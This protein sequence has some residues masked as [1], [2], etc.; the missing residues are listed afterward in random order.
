MV[1]T[2]NICKQKISSAVQSATICKSMK[3]AIAYLC[4]FFRISRSP[5]ERKH[6]YKGY[7]YNLL[8]PTRQN[9]KFR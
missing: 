4:I 5:E 6:A 1:E 9:L 2:I 3:Y 8:R 7:A